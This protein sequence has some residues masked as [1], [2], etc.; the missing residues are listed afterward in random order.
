MLDMVAGLRATIAIYSGALP[1]V[2]AGG[3]PFA[4]RVATRMFSRFSRPAEMLRRR[5][6]ATLTDAEDF[7]NRV[8]DSDNQWWPFAF[9]RPD[10]DER[11]ST[12]RVAILA[13]LQGLPIGLLLIL[14]D[15]AARHAARH[16][17]LSV[18][19][20]TVCVAAFMTNR[21]TLAYFWNRRAERL[22]RHRARFERLTRE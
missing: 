17:R 2:I 3:G 14:V 8:T 16:Q 10:P 5:L 11:F 9:L 1:A 4:A 21:F 20:L 12:R 18:F 22:T 19:L 6:Q 7:F 15:G 13:V